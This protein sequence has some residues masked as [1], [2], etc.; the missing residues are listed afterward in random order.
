[1]KFAISRT[2]IINYCI[3]KNKYISYLEIGVRDPNNGNFNSIKI[4]NKLGV[5]PK[6]KIKQSNIYVGT[7]DDFF[8]NNKQKFD[9]IFIDGLHLEEQVDKDI[10]N[11][12]ECITDKG[13]I[14]LHDCNPP[15]KLH[16]REQ[17]K[18]NGKYPSWNGTVW[19]SIAKLRMTRSDLKINVIDTDWGVGVIKKSK[20]EELY[21]YKENFTYDLLEKDRKKLLKLV[22]AKTFKT[23]IDNLFITKSIPIEYNQLESKQLESNQLESKQLEGN[24]LENYFFNQKKTLLVHKWIHYFNIYDNHFKRFIGKKPTILEIGVFKGGSLEMWNNYFDSDCFIYGIDINPECKKIPQKLNVSNIQIDI[25]DQEDKNFWKQYLVDKPKFDIIIED[26]GHT[27]NQQITT[28]EQVI[29]HVS[30]NGIYLCED[31]HTSY[32]DNFGGGYMKSNTFIEYS[33]KFID[34]LNYY[35]IRNPDNTLKENKQKYQ[36]FRNNIKSVHYYDSIIVLEKGH[37]DKPI[38]LKRH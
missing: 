38:A 18:V 10:I 6:P 37:I 1:M 31:L 5:D 33:K 32:W 36:K 2:D 25:G 3:K 20:D 14:L 23:F 11:S 21:P 35:H 30:D 9:I 26:G 15:T 7:S 22:K 16:Q 13:L 24:K 29:D 12:L 4:K 28:Y 8:K 27:M 19:R 34:M 17:Y